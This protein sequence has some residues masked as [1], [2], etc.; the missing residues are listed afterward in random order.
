MAIE[1][2]HLFCGIYLH[3]ALSLQYPLQPTSPKSYNIRFICVCILIV[4][5]KVK[6]VF[7]LNFNTK[8]HTIH[9]PT[10]K[11]HIVCICHTYTY[12]TPLNNTP[13]YHRYLLDI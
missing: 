13:R 4:G 6:E 10:K 7:V 11:E 9:I 12:N 1:P 3:G 2:S 8:E 5:Y